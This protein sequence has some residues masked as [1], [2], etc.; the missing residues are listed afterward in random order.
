MKKI[1]DLM[2]NTPTIASI[3]NIILEESIY[4]QLESE[5][6]VL[7]TILDVENDTWTNEIVDVEVYEKQRYDDILHQRKRPRLDDEHIIPPSP[8][9]NDRNTISIATPSIISTANPFTSIDTP[10]KANK[11][12]KFKY[13]SELNQMIDASTIGERIM[14]ITIELS[15]RHILAAA[16]DVAEYI[17]DMTRKRRVPINNAPS[18]EAM[19]M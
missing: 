5:G 17:H 18:D 1:F 4:G 11:E 7:V 9:T 13:I 2:T 10:A 8:R 14:D 19:T 12:R 16:P 15:V 3:S 6:I